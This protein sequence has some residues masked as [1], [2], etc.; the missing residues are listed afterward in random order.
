MMDLENAKT[1]T[2]KKYGVTMLAAA[3]EAFC[4]RRHAEATKND[5]HKSVEFEHCRECLRGAAL[6]DLGLDKKPKGETIPGE[7]ETIRAKGETNMA[8]IK[9]KCRT[10]GEYETAR[11]NGRCPKCKA[12]SGAEEKPIIPAPSGKPL[13]GGGA[14]LRRSP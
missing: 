5:G 8:T 10:H 14:T 9:K 6:H 2:C 12:G 13:A 4:A 3:A 7:I 11:T 1:W